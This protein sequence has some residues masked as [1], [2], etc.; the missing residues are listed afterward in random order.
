[1][2]FFV[3]TLF[4]F[5]KFCCIWSIFYFLWWCLQM[6]LNHFYI[7]LQSKLA[8]MSNDFRQVLEVR[9]EVIV[10]PF[11]WSVC[12]CVKCVTY[13][14]RYL[15]FCTQVGVRGLFFFFL[16]S[17]NIFHF[18]LS[19]P[20]LKKKENLTNKQTKE[21]W[22]WNKLYITKFNKHSPLAFFMGHWLVSQIVIFIVEHNI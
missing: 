20:N 2:S 4:I 19:Y 16:F 1:M 12:V 6:F 10:V 15:E 17:L 5:I 11:F 22:K 18:N 13:L 14:F 9:T 3:F 7:I 8:S 21:Y